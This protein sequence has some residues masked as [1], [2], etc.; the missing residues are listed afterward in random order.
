M[1]PSGWRLLVPLLAPADAPEAPPLVVAVAGWHARVHLLTTAPADE[2]GT[3]NGRLEVEDL[4]V[5]RDA[6]RALIDDE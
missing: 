3:A 5:L 1:K 6:A 4:E 2:L